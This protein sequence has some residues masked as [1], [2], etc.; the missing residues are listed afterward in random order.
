MQAFMKAN[1]PLNL[2]LHLLNGILAS[3]LASSGLVSRSI[4]LV[5]MGNLGYK[6]II[7]VGVCQHGADGQQHC[8]KPYI[9]AYSTPIVV[10]GS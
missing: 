5:D 1:H 3:P 9:S 7:G 10:Y 8:R 2:N 4:G 6:R